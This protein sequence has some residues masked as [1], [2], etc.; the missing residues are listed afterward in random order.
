AGEIIRE[1]LCKLPPEARIFLVAPV[2]A[3]FPRSRPGLPVVSRNKA[4]AS[5]QESV[6]P[7][8]RNLCFQYCM[9]ACATGYRMSRQKS[10]SLLTACIVFGVASGEPI[11]RYGK[12]FLVRPRILS[13]AV[14]R[15]PTYLS[16]A[17]NALGPSM[18][19]SGGG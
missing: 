15:L 6:W 5:A 9:A 4:I 3:L 13:K 11:F 12:C 18:W 16:P 14:V 7:S 1:I 17:S 8:L 10:A 2:V 19:V